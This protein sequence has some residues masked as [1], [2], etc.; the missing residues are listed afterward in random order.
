MYYKPKPKK[1][2]TK[3][4]GVTPAQRKRLAALKKKVVAA[5]K[6]AAAKAEK[7]RVDKEIAQLVA[8]LEKLKNK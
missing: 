6:E 2:S 8:K 5:E 7:S 1:R 4:G 3:R